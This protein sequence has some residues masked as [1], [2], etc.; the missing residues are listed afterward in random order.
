M[1]LVILQSQIARDL[2]RVTV[3]V[4]KVQNTV[5]NVNWYKGFNTVPDYL[6]VLFFQKMSHPINGGRLAVNVKVFK[7]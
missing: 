5:R 1:C 3:Q 4:P 6:F 2:T 7:P